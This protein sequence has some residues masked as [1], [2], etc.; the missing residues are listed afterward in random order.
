MHLF[1]FVLCGGHKRSLVPTSIL[2]VSFSLAGNG[3]MSLPCVLNS[4]LD[5]NSQLS[6]PTVIPEFSI[7]F[8]PPPLLP[9]SITTFCY[10]LP[11]HKR[12]RSWRYSML[13]SF[14]TLM[15]ALR[16]LTT[17]VRAKP[18]VQTPQDHSSALV[19]L[20]SLLS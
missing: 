15:S 1:E 10:I 8:P 4:F 12:R 18:L 16:I 14:Q 17:V 7:V 20:G 9:H 6:I 13:I 19:S 5:E 11:Q 3:L 2:L